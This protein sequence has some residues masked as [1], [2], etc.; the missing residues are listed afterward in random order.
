MREK[1]HRITV[2]IGKEPEVL[3]AFA[4]KQ[5]RGRVQGEAHETI[6]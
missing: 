4:R 6:D 2:D 3:F 1:R 5:R